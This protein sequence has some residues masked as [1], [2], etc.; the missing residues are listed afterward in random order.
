[1]AKYLKKFNTHNEYEEYASSGSMIK[2][3]VSYCNDNKDIHF[4]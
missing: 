1:M 3:N 4:N 2:P